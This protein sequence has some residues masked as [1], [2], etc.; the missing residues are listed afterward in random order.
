M[1]NRINFSTSDI[2]K[3]GNKSNYCCAK[4]KGNEN[5]CIHHI[6]PIAKGGDNSVNNLILLCKFC[7][8]LVHRNK[9]EFY[10][11]EEYYKRSSVSFVKDDIIFS[12]EDYHERHDTGW[13]M[14]IDFT[15]HFILKC[16][17]CKS[18][19]II[20]KINIYEYNSL[21]MPPC[22]YFKLK[23]PRCKLVG[24]RKAYLNYGLTDSI[25]LKEE[26]ENE[27]S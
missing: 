24:Q 14:E 10:N 6:V 16:P 19:A 4:C 8:K 3:I 26:L 5:L 22:F 20:S 25:K 27:S 13:Q 9:K 7:H 2:L 12:E 18:E 11:E 15:D 17:K 21:D 1:E 23:C